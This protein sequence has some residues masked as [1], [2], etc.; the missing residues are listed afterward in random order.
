MKERSRFSESIVTLLAS[1]SAR[2]MLSL[3][4]RQLGADEVR[5]M[6]PHRCALFPHSSSLPRPSPLRSWVCELH[7]S[8]DSRWATFGPQ[9]TATL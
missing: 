9:A 6:I 3:A 5:D 8:E 7:G 2:L 4:S 1:S